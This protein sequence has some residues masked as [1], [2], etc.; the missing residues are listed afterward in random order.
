MQD[1]KDTLVP[2]GEVALFLPLQGEQKIHRSTF[3]RWCT[4]GI[5]GV[6]LGRIRIGGGWYTSRQMVAD[7]LDKLQKNEE[8]TGGLKTDFGGSSLF[9]GH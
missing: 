2:L 9:E 8:S 3:H 7:F 5:G 4:R 6:R 1:F